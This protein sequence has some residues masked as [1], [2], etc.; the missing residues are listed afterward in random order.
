MISIH[1]VYLAFTELRKL[2]SSAMRGTHFS[3]KASLIKIIT[4][5]LIKKINIYGFET[6]E[7]ACIKHE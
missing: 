7:T 3:H 4:I 5:T 2:T 1:N 6:I